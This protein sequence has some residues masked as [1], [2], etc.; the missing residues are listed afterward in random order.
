MNIYLFKDMLPVK[1][2]MSPYNNLLES[3]LSFQDAIKPVQYK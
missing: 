3:C 1:T 2:D